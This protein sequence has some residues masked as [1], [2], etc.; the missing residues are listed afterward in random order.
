MNRKSEPRG[1]GMRTAVLVG[2]SVLAMASVGGC[3]IELSE[4]GPR[5]VCDFNDYVEVHGPLDIYYRPVN[6]V[7]GIFCPGYYPGGQG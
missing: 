1:R 6:T 7:V 4:S 2:L 3:H 5:F